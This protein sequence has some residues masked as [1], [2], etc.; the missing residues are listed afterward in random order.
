MNKIKYGLKNVYYAML[1]EGETPTYGTPIRIPGAVSMSLS[2]VGEVTAFVADD[3]E[4]FTAFGNNGY[5]GT[6][7]IALIPQ[8]FAVSA[9]GDTLDDNA[10]QFENAAAQPKP[11]A[12]MFEF[13]G[14][15]KAIKHVLYKS[16]ASRPNIEGSATTNKEVK[17]ETLNLQARPNVDGRVKAKTTDTTD[18]AVIA[19]WNTSVYQYAPITEG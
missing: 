2:P 12:L 6:L 1:T 13:T 4:F 9:L 8:T 18:A 19:A 17:T 10:V 7:E 16:T 11:F 14:D 15:E 5:D 3:V